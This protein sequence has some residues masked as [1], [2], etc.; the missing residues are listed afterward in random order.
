M[1]RNDIKGFNSAT[2]SKIHNDSKVLDILKNINDN[3]KKHDNNSAVFDAK[4]E[5]EQEEESL[6]QLEYNPAAVDQS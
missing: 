6:T 1:N 3:K 4:K 2:I 5:K